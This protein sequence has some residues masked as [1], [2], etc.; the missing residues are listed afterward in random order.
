ME[1]QEEKKTHSP[2]NDARWGS[3]R[4]TVRLIRL[5]SFNPSVHHWTG[6]SPILFITQRNF[7]TACKISRHYTDQFFKDA[8]HQ[9]HGN[10]ENS[11]KYTSMISRMS[12]KGYASSETRSWMCLLR[13]EIP[14]LQQFPVSYE[15]G[16]CTAKVTAHTDDPCETPACAQEISRRKCVRPWTRQKHYQRIH[17]AHGLPSAPHQRK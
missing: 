5:R 3:R 12:I 8:Q 6:Y 1:V 7:S 14:Q 15:S 11:Y 13:V 4:A 9:D 17:P 10:V 2:W 16:D